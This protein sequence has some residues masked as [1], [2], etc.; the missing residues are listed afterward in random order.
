MPEKKELKQWQDMT[1]RELDNQALILVFRML[2][3]DFSVLKIKVFHPNVNK[4][5]QPRPCANYKAT[6][7]PATP[8]GNFLF[9][10]I[11]LFK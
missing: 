4:C 9:L 8:D 1:F 7:G 6:N 2:I 3:K 10:A 11:R 5:S